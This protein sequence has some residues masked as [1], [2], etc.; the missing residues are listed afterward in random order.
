M[1]AIGT[2]KARPGMRIMRPA[3]SA[4]AAIGMKPGACG[5]S[6][7]ITSRAIRKAIRPKSIQRPAR[8]LFGCIAVTSLMTV[9]VTP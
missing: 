4:L 2:T 6:L 3:N 1:A 8:V 7:A 5:T 9:F